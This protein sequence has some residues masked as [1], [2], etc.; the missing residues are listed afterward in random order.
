MQIV[1]VSMVRRNKTNPA[2]VFVDIASKFPW[3]VCLGLSGV[4]YLTLHAFAYQLLKPIAPGH[5][6]DGMIPAVLKGLASAGQY[7]CS[8]SQG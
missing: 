1:G 4:S 5:V 6:A 7:I 3:W 2:D 8:S